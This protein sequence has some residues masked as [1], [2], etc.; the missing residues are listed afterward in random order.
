M[1]D[2]P[3][4]E[5]EASPVDAVDTV[6]PPTAEVEA[7]AV[8]AK[9]DTPIE[10]ATTEAP[11]SPTKPA[12]PDEFVDAADAP[13]ADAPAVAT[14]AAAAPSTPPKP[15]AALPAM[16]GEGKEEAKQV[17]LGSPIAEIK[18]K[19]KPTALQLDDVHVPPRSSIEVSS[20]CCECRAIAGRTRS[21]TSISWSRAARCA[22]PS[23][24]EALQ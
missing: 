5:S 22:T 2:D 7:A 8:D 12:T 9:P 10:P 3:K 16:N 19:R 11:V 23:N 17:E 24:C 14:A 20:E 4:P 18:E 21:A 1:P 6:S 13:I 15:A